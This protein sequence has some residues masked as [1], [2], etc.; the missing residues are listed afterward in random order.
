MRNMRWCG[1]FFL[2][3]TGSAQEFRG[4]LSGRVLDQQQAVVP[5]GRI[6]ATHK[7]TGQKSQTVSGADGSYTLPFLPPGSYTV[8]VD[9]AGF[10]K[11]VNENLQITTNDRV[12]LDITLEVGQVGQSVTVTAEVSLL[13]TATA[14]TGQVINSRQIENM[15]MNG[16]TPLVLAQ[17]A[18]GVTPNSDPKFARPF[19]NAGPSDFS[20]GGAPS[21]SNELLIDGSPDTTRNSRVAYNPPVD[22]VQEVKVETFQSDAAYGHTGGGT[23]NVVLRGGTNNLHGAAY[24]F[25]QVSRLAATPYFTNRSGQK[26]PAGNF[27]Q[28]GINAGGPFYIPKVFQGRDRVFWYFAYEGIKDAF[29]EPLTSTVPTAAERNGDFSQLLSVGANYQMYDPL[30]G[31]QEGSRVRRQPFT[32]NILP[33]SRLSAIAKNYMQFYPLP[34]QAGRADGQDNYL[35]NSVRTDTYDSELGRLDFNLSDRHKFFFNFRH[36]DRLENRS[37]RFFNIATGNLLSRINW[38]SMVDDVYTFSPS[39]VL[40]TRLNWTRFT[41]GNSKPSAGF[42]YTKLGFP[43]YL[44]A[45]SAKFVLPAIDLDQFTDVG[46]DAGDITPFDIYQIFS[47]L[48]KIHGSHVLKFGADLREYRESSASYGNSSGNYQF[49]SDLVRGPLDNSTAAPLG[50]DLTSFLLGYPTGGSFDINTF[51]TQQAKYYSLFVQDDYRV[52]SN[53]MLNLGLRFERDLATTERFNRSANGFDFTTPSPISAQALAAYARTPVAGLPVDQFKV[54]GGL[55]FAAPG[56]P[57]IYQTRSGYFSPR[58][59]FAYTPGGAGRK[60][61]IRGGVGSF[62]FPIGTQGLNQNGFSQSTPILGASATGG[63]RPTSTLENPFP[64]GIQQPTGRSLGLATFLGRGVT[65]FNTQPR[66]PYSVRWTLTV[67]RELGQHLV[68]EIGYTGNRAVHL[69]IDQQLDYLPERFLSTSPARDQ[70]IIDRN[71]ANVANP[72]ANLLPGTGING[73]TVQFNQLVRAFPQFTSVNRQATNDGS[74]YFHG[75]QVRLEKRFSQ[76]LQ[77]L[78]NYQYGR[79]IEKTNRLNDFS[80]P[81]KRP[82]DIDR[83]HRFVTSASYDLPFGRGK[84]VAGEA[85]PVL[86]RIVGG[87][88]INGIYSYESGRTAGDWGNLIYLGGDLHWN[89]RGVDGAFDVTRF[90]R[91]STQQLSNNVRTFPTRFS[92]YRQDA[93]NNADFSIIKNT[94]IKERVNL[95]FRTEFFNGFNHAVFSGPQLGPTSANF[96]T[97]TGVTNLERHIQ[98]ALRLTW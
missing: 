5:S 79:S 16:R 36:N 33:P 10:K 39:L 50:Q 87:W 9:A 60:T 41:E 47:S 89:A 1:L 57:E 31:V 78:T 51:R 7:D 94:P 69:P 27:N 26:K 62:V 85:G 15:P 43:S 12:Q 67:Q 61:V 25:N 90:N 86:N 54:N 63:L 71:S 2:V 4:S 84:A 68:F 3:A 96:G 24:D 32:G 40:N 14:S 95:Q 20:M 97:I 11:Y 58:F 55:L 77:F 59:G 92:T 72:F 70:Q 13:E 48:T 52:R 38:G 88:V 42:D 80:G 30:S 66:N 8:T 91:N 46:T 29:P 37:N 81:A 73:S 98:M 34:N 23:V 64:T 93:T 83:P 17:L 53:L 49:R 21:R 22:S 76:G 82:G 19:D 35:A 65:F 75:L 74:S 56:T 45:N 28:W 44:A 18:F 6:L